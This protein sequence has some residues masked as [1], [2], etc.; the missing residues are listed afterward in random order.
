MRS[1]ARISG[2]RYLRPCRHDAVT[3]V[4]GRDR[5]LAVLLRGGWPADRTSGAH[6]HAD[7]GSGGAEF[8]DATADEFAALQRC[9]PS[10]R[11]HVLSAI[12]MNGDSSKL[13][14]LLDAAAKNL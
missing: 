10:K 7:R 5:Q 3:P 9:Q 11:E 4:A 2:E 1:T 13:G 14:A 8:Q 12:T 6:R